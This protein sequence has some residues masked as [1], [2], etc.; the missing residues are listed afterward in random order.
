[1]KI[2]SVILF[3]ACWGLS[4]AALPL[5][6][7]FTQL[8]AEHLPK[9]WVQHK[10]WS[11]YKP[12]AS[13]K[14]VPGSAAGENALRI[15]NTRAQYGAC[16]RTAR[17]LKGVS[18]DTVTVTLKA[19]GKGTAWVGL[20]F[21]TKD[22]KWN[23]TS[24]Q[25]KFTLTGQW[26]SHTFHFLI[27][28]GTTGETGF[29]DVT[30]GGG[31]NLE[32]EFT[33]I[34]AEQTEAEYRGN[35][36]FPIQWTVFAPVSKEFTPSPD[37]LR[38]IPATLDGVRG[39]NALLQGNEF[40]FAQLAG[41]QEQGLCGW[42]FAELDSPIDCDY[43]IGAGADWWMVYY[44]NGKKAID[45]SD[46]G[47]QKYPCRINNHLAVVRLKKGKNIL[48]VKLIAGQ[49][50]SILALGGP[51]DLR[52]L[53]TRLKVV[54]N[55]C[56]DDYDNQDVSR[57]GNPEIIQGNPTPGLLSITGQGVYRTASEIAIRLP[58]TQYT[59]PGRNSGD[60]FA[61]GVRI[62]NFGRSKRVN[63][64]LE[65]QFKAGKRSFQL[66]ILHDKNAQ[67]LLCRFIDGGK[68]LKTFA[69]PYKVL[70]A[71]F[72]FAANTE[73]TFD[74]TV[75]SLADSSTTSCR[76]NA[77]FFKENARTPFSTELVFRSREKQTAE[78][79]LD[80]YMTGIAATEIKSS[81]IPFKTELVRKFDPIQ[82]GWKL[83]FSDEFNGTEVDWSKWLS[84]GKK[85][86]ASLDG[87][88]H[89]LIKAD[90]A[91]DG[92]KLETA[93]LWSRQIFKY[94]YFESRLRF[95]KQPGWWAAFW[96]Y[97]GT[98][99]NPML[100]GFEIDIFEDYYTRPK[101]K[102]GANDGIL[103]HNLHVYTGSLLKSW[104]YNSRLPGS[105]DDFYVIGCKWTP[106]EISYYL[107]GR[108]IASSANHSPYNTVTFDAIHHATGITPLH[109]IVSGQVMRKA[110]NGLTAKEGSFP[111]YFEVDYVRV[112]EYP[113]NDAPT[114]AWTSD[115]AGIFVPEGSRLKFAADAKP[116]PET[117][118]PI[119]TAY[120]FDN[121][122]LIDCRT[123]PPYEFDVTFNKAFY[124]KTHYMKAGRS[125]KK[126]DFNGYVHAFSIFVQDARGK[127][128]HTE[129]VL[130]IRKPS[131]MSTP[132][133]GKAQSIPGKINPAF[134]DEGGQDVAYH[135]T[136]PQNYASKT[137][138]TAE[139][140]DAGGSAIG[141]VT[142]GEWL[143][144][145]VDIRKAG[146]YKAVLNYGTPLEGNHRMMLL[147]D[148]KEIGTFQLKRHETDHWSCDSFAVLENLALPAG[149]HV[150]TLLLI[151]GFNFS[152]LEFQEQ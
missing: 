147:L 44:V 32:G 101:Q 18:G 83:V 94:G 107:N 121:G 129:K 35:L 96:L 43:T 79:V 42:A 130:K 51:N 60:W 92:K 5:D 3:C 67:D 26:T 142:S 40:D 91:S 72:L 54:K 34:Q 56:I 47:N 99:A 152:T 28:D 113:M 76:G 144:Y 39:R 100:D 36:N 33:S 132:Y 37:Q 109:A 119:R 57:S 25:Q 98:N 63:A 143:N 137:F 114:V 104:N 2:I 29:F 136:T 41:R 125:G 87:K 75:N 105:L 62:Q 148:G 73:G 128:A 86:N 80:N 120:L 108:Q 117:G 146:K 30:F 85:E 126:P 124:D 150:L 88:G 103:D 55:F 141:N 135:D 7:N 31:Q 102:G 112:Y 59:L 9:Q 21:Y 110:W 22:G 90:F 12:Y 123:E 23:Q 13:I 89:L 19:R 122:Y 134:Y 77:P 52:A 81:A 1:M 24:P 50:S 6:G 58:Q 46:I 71:D 53:T 78:T 140:V 131:R 118:A 151:G 48:A 84:H 116:S 93:S 4:G 149:R 14:I 133:Q 27:A 68:L 45:T 8:D 61:T 64:S 139:A 115:N 82:A 138:R 49:K 38:T 16:V 66:E 74:L 20:Y 97:G 69:V 65:F 10:N 15:F 127:V 11:G 95:T 106:F 70:P 17:R 145:T 111:E